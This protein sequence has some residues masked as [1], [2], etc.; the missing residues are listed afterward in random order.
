MG[1]FLREGSNE[2]LRLFYRQD[3]TLLTLF[4][5]THISCP[6]VERYGVVLFLFGL[7]FSWREASFRFSGT[8]FGGEELFVDRKSDHN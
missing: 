3:S 1:S 2:G 6:V 7:S 5:F 8:S 4:P